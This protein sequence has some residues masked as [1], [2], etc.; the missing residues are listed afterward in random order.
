MNTLSTGP[1]SP[2]AAR[3][4][5]TPARP[6]SLVRF[7]C[8]LFA[9]MSP[10]PYQG[11]DEFLRQCLLTGG[12]SMKRQNQLK[13][14]EHGDTSKQAEAD[15]HGVKDPGIRKAGWGIVYHPDSQPGKNEASKPESPVHIEKSPF[16]IWSEK[17]RQKF[18][19]TAEKAAQSHPKLL[20]THLRE[21]HSHPPQAE[22]DKNVHPFRQGDWTLMQHGD[23]PAVLTEDLE[24]K[25]KQWGGP[26]P[27]GQVDS[28]RIA[29]YVAARLKQKAGTTNIA[30]RD[31]RQVCNDFRDIVREII[32]NPKAKGV[33]TYNLVLSDGDRIFVTHYSATPNNMFVGRHEN[34]TGQPEILLV[35]DRLQPTSKSGVK[36]IQWQA[37]P[38]KQII[39][40][41]R[42]QTSLGGS[43]VSYHT[44]PLIPPDSK[45]KQRTKPQSKPA[46]PNLF[47]ALMAWPEQLWH[48]LKISFLSLKAKLGKLFKKFSR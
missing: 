42:T 23:F 11:Q 31:T 13:M 26:L 16:A 29:C 30:H 10:Q 28:E 14:G 34:A 5:T 41:E 35:T 15:F 45:P 12:N 22:I 37:V 1:F 44:E 19:S 25:L 4:Q 43:K 48:S 3:S 9:Y 20:L 46:K 21:A 6:A 17:D 47:Q 33:G 18:A 36:A 8:R 2:F 7:G 38:D 40:L 27:E 24:A 32:E 39:S